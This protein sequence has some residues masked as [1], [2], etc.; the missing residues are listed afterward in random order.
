MP[1]CYSSGDERRSAR[2]AAAGSRVLPSPLRRSWR[3]SRASSRRSARASPALVATSPAV[4]ASPPTRAA[5]TAVLVAPGA[6]RRAER[7]AGVLGRRAGALFVAVAVGFVD[8]LGA[9]GLRAGAVDVRGL[10]AASALRSRSASPVSCSR[11]SWI[12]SRRRSITFRFLAGSG[13][14]I[15]HAPVAPTQV[16]NFSR[17]PTH[18]PPHHHTRTAAPSQRD[19]RQIHA[20]ALSRCHERAWADHRRL[21][22]AHP[23][24]TDPVRAGLRLRSGI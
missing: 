5:S 10:S 6:V 12:C 11:R 9:G 15:V 7:V 17:G 18:G 14:A 23:V 8:W 2:G 4:I 24:N 22:H 19:G 16:S 13:R 3:A 21:L 1:A 20:L